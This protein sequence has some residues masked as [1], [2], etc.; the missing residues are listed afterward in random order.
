MSERQIE[1]EQNVL[2]ESDECDITMIIMEIWNKE[3][4]DIMVC[5]CSDDESYDMRVGRDDYRTD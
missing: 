1:N 4:D 5:R 2:S 3:I